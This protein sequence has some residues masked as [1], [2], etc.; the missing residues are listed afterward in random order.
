MV[1]D[2]GRDHL[3]TGLLAAARLGE[4]LHGETGVVE[5]ARG[6][7]VV[8]ALGGRVGRSPASRPAGR[9]G[10]SR[11]PRA[12][13]APAR[14]ASRAW[15][16]GRR[17][18][19]PAPRRGRARRGRR[20]GGA[21][22]R[23]AAPCRGAAWRRS[24]RAHVARQV[25][26]GSDEIIGKSQY[27]TMVSPCSQRP[28]FGVPSGTRPQRMAEGAGARA[29]RKRHRLERAAMAGRTGSVSVDGGRVWYRRLGPRGRCP[30]PHRARRAGRRV[31]LPRAVRRAA[32][33][34]APRRDLRSARLRQV[35]QARRHEPVDHRSLVP[36]ARPGA[37][38]AGPGLVSSAGA[39]VGR[40]AVHRVPHP[41]RGRHRRRR[42]GVDVGQPAAVRRRGAP[43]DRRD[44]RARAHDPAR[45]RRPRRLRRPALPGRGH[46]VL[47]S[48]SLPARPLARLR[49]AQRRRARRA[50][51]ST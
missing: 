26:V 22:R 45:A 48:P 18:W 14:A 40:L 25:C 10:A 1:D 39:V 24:R 20:G 3:A 44:A 43:P 51:R 31:V 9:R 41:R 32:G 46:G 8:E 21:V 33:A 16:P 23:A 30:R 12:A 13:R 42:A 6:P 11:R 2:V 47:P 7:P 35:R 27:R 19:P 4:H 17:G 37:R 36:R 49:P 29:L 34:A 5:R 50:T 28:A 15:W 38:R